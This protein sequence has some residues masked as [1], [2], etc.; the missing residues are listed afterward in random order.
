MIQIPPALR[1][2]RFALYWTGL[3]ISIAGGQMQFWALLWHV[4]RMTN[5]PIVVSGIGLVRFLPILIFSMI[6]GAVADTFNRRT[7]MFLTQTTM[8]LVAGFLGLLTLG[9][10]I[11]IWHI[12]LLTGIQAIAQSFDMPARQALTPNLLPRELYPNG[13]SLQSIAFNTGS[14]VG[15]ALSGIV[16]SSMGLHWVYFINAISFIAV[17]VALVLIGDVRQ[18]SIPA[19]SP[20]AISMSA[21]REGIHFIIRSPIILSSMILDF[22]ATFFSSANTL[23]PFVANQILHVGVFQY[24]WLSAGQSIGAVTV[25]LL[26]S[27][28]TRIQRQGKLLL[29]AVTCFGI[30]TAVFGL[31]RSFILTLIALIFTGASDSVSTILRN[32]I[33]QL[34][35]PDHIRGRMVSIN[36]IFFSGG[37]QLGEIEAG[38]VAQTFGLPAAIVSGGLGCIVTVLIV[39]GRWPQLW[40]YNGDEPAAAMAAAD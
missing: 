35:T 37:P 9:G 24:G 29:G 27:Q 25:A 33:R 17:L 40:Q 28:R 3:L 11:Q 32:T 31:S 16:I 14:I 39:G 4:S 8:M 26:F 38:L 30:A 19:S 23:L 2:R 21:I 6:A 36:Q 20:R 12:Y 34:Q 1:E 18:S 15:P 22:F 5:H 7:I 13:F 10:H